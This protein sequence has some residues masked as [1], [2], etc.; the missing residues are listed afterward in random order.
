MHSAV[1]VLIPLQKELD[2]N[3]LLAITNDHI[4]ELF[5]D[6]HPYIS[7]SF[8]D[9][10]LVNVFAVKEFP[11]AAAFR[12]HQSGKSTVKNPAHRKLLGIYKS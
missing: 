8:S 7:L 9:E 10:D 5:E 1:H 6:S 2:A 4:F 3:V 12:S 11:S